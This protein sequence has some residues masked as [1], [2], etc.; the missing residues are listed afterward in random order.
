LQ[1]QQKRAQ[2]EVKEITARVNVSRSKASEA[3][4]A[5]Q[6]LLSEIDSLG[7]SLKCKHC[8]K[9]GSVLGLSILC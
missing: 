7:K 8:L 9:P 4:A 1:D 3:I 2:Q 6:Y 5:E